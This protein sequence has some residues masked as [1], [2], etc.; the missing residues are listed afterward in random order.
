MK[1]VDKL[2]RWV[3]N[4]LDANAQLRFGVLLVLFSIPFYLYLPFSGEPP[5]VYLM[6]ALALTVSGLSFLIGAE[7]L[8]NQEKGKK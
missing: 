6:S 8:L 4:K 2:A 7:V 1:I 5:I 3:A